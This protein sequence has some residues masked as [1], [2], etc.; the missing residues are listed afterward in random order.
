[1]DYRLCRGSK[2]A[3]GGEALTTVIRAYRKKKAARCEEKGGIAER[4]LC[5]PP[6]KERSR[7]MRRLW[8]ADLLKT[9]LVLA[10]CGPVID[11]VAI[12]R[13]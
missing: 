11:S 12:R 6:Q 10:T 8:S 7:A 4:R 9:L 2:Q 1:M 3:Q 13:F 5:P